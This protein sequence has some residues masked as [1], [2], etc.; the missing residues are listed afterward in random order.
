L[1]LKLQDCLCFRPERSSLRFIGDQD[2]ARLCRLT[3]F[4][5]EQAEAAPGA[6]GKSALPGRMISNML[7]ATAER[8]AFVASLNYDVPRGNTVSP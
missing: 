8:I 1:G 2:N 4:P 5:G 3:L 6:I 7:V